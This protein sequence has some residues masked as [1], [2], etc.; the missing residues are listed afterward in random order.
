MK[1][2]Y[3]KTHQNQV[4]KKNID[5]P[6][7]INKTKLPL[8][9]YHLIEDELHLVCRGPTSVILQETASII[10]FVFCRVTT[11][12]TEYFSSFTKP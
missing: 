8:F 11:F 3:I 7:K 10:S 4:K 2:N 5:E 6:V 12:K 9:F 1:A